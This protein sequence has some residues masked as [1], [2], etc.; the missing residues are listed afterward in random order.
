MHF[1]TLTLLAIKL[2]SVVDPDFKSHILSTLTAS[3][4]NL[5]QKTQ[6]LEDSTELL[7]F[8]DTYLAILLLRSNFPHDQFLFEERFLYDSLHIINYFTLGYI[9][10]DHYIKNRLNL[11]L[12]SHLKA[13]ISRKTTK[14]DIASVPNFS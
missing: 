4:S 8:V 6:S 7:L 3:Y 12:A 1:I 2:P 13:P 5:F 10:S 11:M 14:T 9:I